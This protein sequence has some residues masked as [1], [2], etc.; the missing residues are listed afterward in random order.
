MS[1]FSVGEMKS[2]K[3]ESESFYR[4][5]KNT[6][7]LLNDE[8]LLETCNTQLTQDICMTFQ[9]PEYSLKVM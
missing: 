6:Y 3:T 1:S 9:L 5:K 2:F 4:L 8:F 7:L